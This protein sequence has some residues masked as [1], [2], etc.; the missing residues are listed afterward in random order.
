MATE[1]GDDLIIVN[2]FETCGLDE[3]KS[4]IIGYGM[5]IVDPYTLETIRSDSYK[6]KPQFPVSEGAKAVNGYTEKEWE[7]ALW[8]KEALER[9]RDFKGDV[10]QFASW[11]TWF[12]RRHLEAEA[13][14]LG[15]D[16]GLD[17]HTIDIVAIFREK[18]W[19]SGRRLERFSLDQAALVLGLEP[20]AKPHLPLQ[21]VDK[22]LE[23][24]RKLRSMS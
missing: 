22:A 11:N 14:R 21:G 6:A 4:T 2:D 23:V 9:Y 8:P 7:R 3:Q 15:F 12:D 10:K 24:W 18:M 17:Y 16:I 1:L 13:R 20:E 5:R 19:R